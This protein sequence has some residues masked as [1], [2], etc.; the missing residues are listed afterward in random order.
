MKSY[1]VICLLVSQLFFRLSLVWFL[2]YT[3]YRLKTCTD[4]YVDPKLFWQGIIPAAVSWTMATVCA[5]CITKNPDP[6]TWKE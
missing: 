2:A 1:E 5:A 4:D 3:V 6:T